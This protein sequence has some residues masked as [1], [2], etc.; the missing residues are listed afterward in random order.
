MS[1]ALT[2]PAREA[3]AGFCSASFALSKPEVTA[4]SL[5]LPLFLTLP[6][7]LLHPLDA[8]LGGQLMITSGSLCRLVGTDEQSQFITDV[9]DLSTDLSVLVAPSACV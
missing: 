2:S 7:T 5:D 3:V 1:N 8:L 6:L 4:S 9:G